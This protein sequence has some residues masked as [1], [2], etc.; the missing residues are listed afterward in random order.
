MPVGDLIA[1]RAEA[2]ILASAEGT[3]EARTD[4]QADNQVTSD[5]V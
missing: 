4:S 3:A 5:G 1:E 2:S